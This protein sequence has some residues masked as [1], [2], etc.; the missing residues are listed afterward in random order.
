MK[1]L[2]DDQIASLKKKLDEE[3]ITLQTRITELQAQDPF[4]DPERVND[5]AASDSEANEESSH[6]R[7]SAM[8]TELE[9]T[10]S[11]IEAAIKKMQDGTY[12]SCTNCGNQIE[13]ERLQ[14]L[15]TARLCLPCE[16][17]KKQVVQIKN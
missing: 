7:F 9:E 11:Q 13:P 6:D 12:G 14:I 15:P 2:S 5:N 1:K 17:N 16:Q 3:K 8:V 4:S 10:I